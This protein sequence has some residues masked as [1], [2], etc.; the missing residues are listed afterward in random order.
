M[1][2]LMLLTLSIVKSF[3][4]TLIFPDVNS[5]PTNNFANVDFPLPFRPNIVTQFPDSIEK[6]ILSKTLF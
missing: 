2:S 4:N 6:V 5:N 1:L 3:P